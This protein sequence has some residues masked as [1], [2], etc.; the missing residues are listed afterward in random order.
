MMLQKM[1]MQIN[2]LT[3]LIQDLLDVSKVESGRLK[4]QSSYFNVDELIGE[5]VEEIQRTAQTYT[6][7]IEGKTGKTI[8]ADRE[9][10]GQVLTNFFTNAVK[11]SPKHSD[12]FVST[13]SNNHEVT[14]CVKDFGVGIPKTQL[15]HVFD[16]FYRV[17]GKTHDTVPGMGLGLNIAA[18][19]VK[20]H[21]GKIWAKSILGKGSEFY[22]TLPIDTA[23]ISEDRNNKKKKTNNN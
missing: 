21:N 20:R 22:F 11:Y 15:Q 5:I 3:N 9:R 18:E 16:R 1:D 8:Y 23:M 10:I 2:K 14:I 6:I 17:T 12:I 4:M 19:I 7:V 13:G